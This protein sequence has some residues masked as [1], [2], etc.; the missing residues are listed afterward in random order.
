MGVSVLFLHVAQ[1][2]AEGL[3]MPAAVQ[4]HP[5]DGLEAFVLR[6]LRFDAPAKLPP[7]LLTVQ[8]PAEQGEVNA[9]EGAQGGLLSLCI[10]QRREGDVAHTI[11]ESTWSSPPA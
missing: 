9:A 8:V 5:V 10:M 11:N 1:G 4:P 7:L 2:K 6:R 3:R